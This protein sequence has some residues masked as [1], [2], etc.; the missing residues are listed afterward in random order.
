MD[1]VQLDRFVLEGFLGAGAD[2]EAH[3]ATDTETGGPVVIKRPNPDYIRRQMHVR[4]DALSEQLV[5]VHRAVGESAHF[6][7]HLVG[8]TDVAQHDGYFG[9]DLKEGYRVLV[10]ERARG[11][12]L[13]CDIRDRFKGVPIG[14]GQNL[15]ALHSLVPDPNGGCFSIQRQLL[16][17]EEAFHNAGHLALDM[18]PQNIY[19]DPAEARITAIDIGAT[20]TMGEAFQGRLS[21]GLGPKD[22]H[23]FFL[24]VFRFYATPDHPPSSPGTYGEPAGM[25]ALPGFDQQVSALLQDFA[26]VSPGAL[27]EAAL[28]A[29]HKI[30]DRS[31]GSFREFRADF[32]DYLDLVEER[33]SSLPNLPELL[34]VWTEALGMLSQDYWK[35]YRFDP[36]SNLAHYRGGVAT[37]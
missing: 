19:F 10:E 24:E 3:A 7:A 37:S 1:R 9:D 2:Y 5:Q 33:N 12:P 18:R 34:G 31:Y 36:D 13:V 29:L 16:D 15:F 32:E 35:M 20:P 23:D 26:V 17:L 30:Q 28:G 27:K 22:F 6:L 21:L 25:R 8:Y 11:I 14:L 4:I